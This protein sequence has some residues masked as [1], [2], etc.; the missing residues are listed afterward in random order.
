MGIKDF[1]VLFF[2]IPSLAFFFGPTDLLHKWEDYKFSNKKDN[3][4]AWRDFKKNLCGVYAY[5]KGNLK[6]KNS[7]TFHFEHVNNV[8]ISHILCVKAITFGYQVLLILT[9]N[10]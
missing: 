6:P 5:D 9:I 10:Y 1:S 3:I 2:L 4:G 7:S 8:W